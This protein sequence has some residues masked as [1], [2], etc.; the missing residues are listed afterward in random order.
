MMERFMLYEDFAHAAGT[1]RLAGQPLPPEALGQPLQDPAQGYV[2]QEAL[3]HWFRAQGYGR[4]A[5]YKIGATT[6]AMQE[7]LGVDEPLCGR[8]LDRG[9]VEPGSVLRV[10]GDCPIGLECELAFTLAEDLPKRDEPWRRR[11]ILPFLADCHAALEVAENRYGDFRTCP[12]GVIVGDDVFHRAYALGTPAEWRAEDLGS[13]AGRITIDGL[14]VQTGHGY[15]V[16]GNPL[17]AVVWLANAAPRIGCRLRRGQIILTGS[18][19]LVH[20]VGTTPAE[21]GVEI[22]GIGSLAITLER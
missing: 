3:A 19:T 22:D 13:I 15:D 4:Q 1:A 8:L 7:Y 12:V 16:M 2:A 20:W 5:G 11:T 18:M 17:E 14:T 9:R 21:V 6:S 10:S